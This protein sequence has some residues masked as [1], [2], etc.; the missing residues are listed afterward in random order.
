[1]T[2]D[3]VVELLRLRWRLTDGK[4]TFND[5]KVDAWHSHLSRH[6]Y[7][8]LRA[9]MTTT[10]A[11]TLQDLTS[12]IK[13]PERDA[14]THS[15]SGEAYLGWSDPRAQ[16]AFRKGYR[17]ATGREWAGADPLGGAA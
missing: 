5:E 4:L 12:G 2:R 10:L 16:A 8:R 11:V 15:K 1:M 9:R 14:P 13:V 7:G 3:E 6:D 17:E